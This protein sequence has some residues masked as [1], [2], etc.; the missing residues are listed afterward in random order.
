MA[1][2]QCLYL[3]TTAQIVMFTLSMIYLA[4]Q[5][6]AYCN[7][8]NA[9][10]ATDAVLSLVDELGAA[11]DAMNAEG[12]GALH[13]AGEGGHWGTALQ[14]LKVR[15]AP[16]A[17]VLR[18]ADG[19]GATVPSAQLALYS[20]LQ[21]LST[22]DS[23]EETV[24]PIIRELHALDVSFDAVRPNTTSSTQDAAAATSTQRPVAQ[25]VSVLVSNAA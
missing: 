4:A 17:A 12:K 25:S 11:V 2:C 9:G 13:A 20:L 23:A 10:G 7:N 21:L 24:L 18:S 6:I 14:L 1:E 5:L 22:S 3:S 16:H 15:P 8:F 19:T